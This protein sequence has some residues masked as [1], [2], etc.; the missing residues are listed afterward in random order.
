M[1][2]SEGPEI[3]DLLGMGGSIAG[4]LIVGFGVGWW[5]DR[6]LDSFPLWALVGLGLGIIAA[7]LYMYSQF[8]KFM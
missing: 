2:R 8:K 7:S 6:S 1:A 3:G 4:L 5:I